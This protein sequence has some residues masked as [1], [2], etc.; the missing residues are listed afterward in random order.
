MADDRAGGLDVVPPICPTCKVA[1]LYEAS[2]PQLGSGVVAERHYCP[3]C[4]W[5]PEVDDDAHN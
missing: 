4:G 5:N 3:L 2:T 1:C